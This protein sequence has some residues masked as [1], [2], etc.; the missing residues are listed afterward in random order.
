MP[1]VHVT[2]NRKQI[3]LALLKTPA[4]HEQNQLKKEKTSR[5]K[6]LTRFRLMLCVR[7]LFLSD[8][9]NPSSLLSFFFFPFF[10]FYIDTVYIWQKIIIKRNRFLTVFIFVLP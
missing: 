5:K 9:D 4:T 7:I 6:K 8:S 10:L 3:D 1:V 2:F